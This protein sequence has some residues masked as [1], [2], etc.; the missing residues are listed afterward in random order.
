MNIITRIK[1]AIISNKERKEAK[2][3]EVRRREIIDGKNCLSK[4]SGSK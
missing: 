2:R 1:Q 3:K 4:C